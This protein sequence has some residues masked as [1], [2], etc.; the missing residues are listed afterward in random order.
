MRKIFINL[1]FLFLTGFIFLFANSC[2]KDGGH[3]QILAIESQIHKMINDY[4]V[5]LGRN[6]LVVLPELFMEARTHSLKMANGVIPF[7][8]EGLDDVFNDL[9]SKLGGTDT[10]AIVEVTMHT[11]ADSIFNLIVSNTS[12]EEI[13]SGNFTQGGVG[14]ASDKNNHNYITILFLNI[15]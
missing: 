11:V 8:Y 14:F 15:P 12:K 13:I 6:A 9:K 2:E 4:R 1:R 7:G 10:W 5:T 3:H